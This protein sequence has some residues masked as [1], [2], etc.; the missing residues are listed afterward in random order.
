MI[1]N[2]LNTVTHGNCLDVMKKLPDNCIDLVL[3]DPPYFSGPERR[4][5]YG[6]SVSA[7][8]VKRTKYP[9]TEKWETPSNEYFEELIRISKNQIIWGCNYFDYNFGPGRIVWDKVNGSSTFSD[10][11]IAFCSLQ[12][13][14]RMISYMW[15]GMMQGRSIKDGKTAQGNKKLNEKRQHPTQKPVELM[16]W[17]LEKYLLKDWKEGRRPIIFDG[18]AGSGTTGVAAKKCG[19]DFIL[20]EK[21]KQ[22]CDIIER[23]LAQETL[24]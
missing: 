14:V 9:V 11:E 1:E 24:F 16:T 8:G 13:S 22:Y 7:P 20:V 2:L 21:E 19:C 4:H 15:N 10:C 5:F 17:C 3:T 12:Y 23:R 18:F 6:A